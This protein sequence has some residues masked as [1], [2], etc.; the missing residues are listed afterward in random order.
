MVVE[1]KPCEH[2]GRPLRCTHCGG[3][4]FHIRE[5]A[6]RTT[7]DELLRQP[8]V[9]DQLKAYICGNCGNVTWFA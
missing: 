3:E 2:L 1:A 4:E 6:V 9:A 5:Y 7:E 8:W